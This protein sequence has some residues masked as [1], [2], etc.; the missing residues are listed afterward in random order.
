ME[1]AINSIINVNDLL[2]SNNMKYGDNFILFV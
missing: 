1:F 2:F